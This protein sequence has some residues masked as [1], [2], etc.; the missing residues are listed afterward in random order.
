MIILWSPFGGWKRICF[1]VYGNII[2]NS[3]Y[4]EYEEVKTGNKV[5]KKNGFI[6]F[7]G[8]YF[9]ARYIEL[10]LQVMQAIDADSVQCAI[11][12]YKLYFVLPNIYICV[13]SLSKSIDD[14]DDDFVTSKL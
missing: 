14:D 5:I 13:T 3:R 8:K 7:D 2:P 11:K 12:D 9:N 4:I 10:I 1:I 6:S